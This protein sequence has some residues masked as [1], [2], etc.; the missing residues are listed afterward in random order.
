MGQSR[1]SR[2]HH[3]QVLVWSSTI[4]YAHEDRFGCCGFWSTTK[5]D[6]QQ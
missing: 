5:V 2:K 1:V 4:L 3:V 6:G